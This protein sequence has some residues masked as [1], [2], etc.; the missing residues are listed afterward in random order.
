MVELLSVN[1]RESLIE[2]LKLFMR[3]LEN[4]AG[5]TNIDNTLKQLSSQLKWLTIDVEGYLENLSLPMTTSSEAW[6]LL[7]H[8]IYSTTPA[9]D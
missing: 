3:D 5:H 1:S 7:G 8:F 2:W 4:A 9:L 6:N